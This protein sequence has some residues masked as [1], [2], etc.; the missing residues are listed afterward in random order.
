MTEET[1]FPPEPD[2][3]LPQRTPGEA[4]ARAQSGTGD[5]RGAEVLISPVTPDGVSLI[6]AER[7]RQ[8]TE[9]GWTP[10]HDNSHTK[11]ELANAAIAYAM[12][13]N[14]N[15]HTAASYWP[16]RLSDWKPGDNRVRTLVK[17]GALLAAEIDRLLREPQ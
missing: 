7:R 11:G 6:A 2:L 8:V 12:Y 1:G 15:G 17:A 14:S 16:W 9:E 5:E 10:E 3:P 4:L 13:A